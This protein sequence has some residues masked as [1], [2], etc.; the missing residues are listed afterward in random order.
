M[1][2]FGFVGKTIG[3]VVGSNQSSDKVSF[4]I[5]IAGGGGETTKES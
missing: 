5:L 1:R 4:K 3:H 2:K